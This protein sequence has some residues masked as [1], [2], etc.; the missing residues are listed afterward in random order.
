MRASA[1]RLF[2]CPTTTTPLGGK[3]K[4]QLSFIF[5]LAILLSLFVFAQ[6]I[7]SLSGTVKDPKGAIVVGAQVTARNETTGTT[8]TATT[9]AQGKFSLAELEA[10]NYVVSIARDGFK[11]SEQKVTLE[12]KRT[13]T[14]EIKLEIAE[15]RGEVTTSAI[16]TIKPNTDPNYRA[17]RD[18]KPTETFTVTNLTLKRDVGTITLKTG[19]I[20]FLPPVLNRVA[21]GVFV[22]EG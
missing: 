14:L 22:G 8:K 16:G 6:A 4:R 2:S 18:G 11:A 10:G 5:L 3:M 15:V 21:I 13:A 12:D 19:R 20:S 1:A 9:D 17:L 7:G